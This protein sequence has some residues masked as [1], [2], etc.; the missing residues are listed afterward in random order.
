MVFKNGG[1]TKK[2]FQLI[3]D[4]MTVPGDHILD[5]MAPQRE[6]VMNPLSYDQCIV[7][8]A[9]PIKSSMKLMAQE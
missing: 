8:T 3:S 2:L 9:T 5:K 6:P 1:Q 4:G 7:A